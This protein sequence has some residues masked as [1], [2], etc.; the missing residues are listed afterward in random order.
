MEN[1]SEV[2]HTT[3]DPQADLE[4]L[5]RSK[6]AVAIDD[7][8]NFGPWWYAP[9]LA[10][11]V[12]GLTLFGQD[13][14]YALNALYAIAGFGSGALMAVH[15]YRRR[16]VRPKFS[17]TSLGLIVGIV[18]IMWLTVAA[19]GTAISTIGYDDFVILPAVIA[20]TITAAAFLAIRQIL[21]ALL[22]RRSVIA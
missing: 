18:A 14:D 19:W 16:T 8:L 6:S 17:F 22:A 20:W 7:V 2:R 21:H 10:T 3:F 9:L 13:Y 4:L 12:G 5:Q 15:D 11:C 1:T